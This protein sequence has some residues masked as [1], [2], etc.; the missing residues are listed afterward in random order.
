LVAFVAALEIE[1]GIW[2][3]IMMSLNV[4]NALMNK[5]QINLGDAIYN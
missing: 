5:L 2:K 1:N 3:N 4:S